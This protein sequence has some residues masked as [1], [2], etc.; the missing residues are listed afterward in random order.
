MPANKLLYLDHLRENYDS[1][2]CPGLSSID[3]PAID[4]FAQAIVVYG[5]AAVQDRSSVSSCA[6]QGQAFGLRYS[7][8]WRCKY[9]ESTQRSVA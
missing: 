4:T 2:F 6:S 1:F 8:K 7:F 9:K 3:V 5:S